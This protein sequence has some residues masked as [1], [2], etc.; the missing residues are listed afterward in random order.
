[1]G[2]PGLSTERQKLGYI[3]TLVVVIAIPSLVT[4]SPRGSNPTLGIVLINRS[5]L[6]SMT[7]TLLDL[8]FAT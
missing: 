4:A 1:V 7:E 6:V 2:T 3:H 8:A 5:P